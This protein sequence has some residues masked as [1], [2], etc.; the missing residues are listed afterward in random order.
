LTSGHRSSRPVLPICGRAGNSCL[1]DSR[2]KF[3]GAQKALCHFG[4]NG[5]NAL[6]FFLFL[7]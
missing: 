1:P 2:K 4:H 6:L 3:T 7:K 5:Q